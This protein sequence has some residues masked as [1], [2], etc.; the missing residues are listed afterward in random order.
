MGSLK[1]T[2]HDTCQ[3]KICNRII[4]TWVLMFWFMLTFSQHLLCLCFESNQLCIFPTSCW[5]PYLI[6][7][8]PSFVTWPDLKPQRQ[9][10]FLCA[11][12]LTSNKW[13][14]LGNLPP[15][16][17]FAYHS[18]FLS[19]SPSHRI[20]TNPFSFCLSKNCSPAVP[21]FFI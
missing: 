17:S 3:N 11:K 18:I 12:N 13:Q 21:L 2:D 19:P 15:A 5:L 6:H 9:L 10:L 14:S 7:G 1:R 8:V 4:Y 20:S 16:M